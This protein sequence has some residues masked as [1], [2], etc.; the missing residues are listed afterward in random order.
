MNCRWCSYQNL[1][2]ASFCGSCGRDLNL[3]LVCASCSTPNPVGHSFC[4]ACGAELETR[5]DSTAVDEAADTPDEASEDKT[6]A[7]S[8]TSSSPSVSESAAA[9]LAEEL[10]QVVGGEVRFDKMSRALYSTDASIYQIEPVGVVI[11]RDTDDVVAA[12]ETSARHGV[13]ILPRGGGT[14]L[15]GQ[16]VGSALVI[17]FSKYMRRLVEL[18]VEE[19]WARVQPGIVLDELNS[20]LRPSGVL[21]APDPSTSNRGNV[22]GSA[23][24]QLVRV[25]LDQVGE[26]HRPHA[27]AR[28]GALQ[29]R[30]GEAGGSERRGTADPRTG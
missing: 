26:D 18:N 11:P 27:G 15:A 14:S 13:P 5:P 22:G 8:R 16:T 9:E 28:R 10:R 30:Y 1:P 24:Q 25:P 19:G 20:L 2:R 29:R 6:P 21:F 4:D 23:R 3:N 12:V 17:D 7:P